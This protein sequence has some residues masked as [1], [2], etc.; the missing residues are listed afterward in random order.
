MG[1]GHGAA[2]SQRGDAQARLARG[3][4]DPPLAS[5]YFYELIGEGDLPAFLRRSILSLL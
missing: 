3:V 1:H 4:Y 5:G 2:R